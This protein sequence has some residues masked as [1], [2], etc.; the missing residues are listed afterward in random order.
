V[1]GE[2]EN[3]N[4]KRRRREGGGERSERTHAMTRD[5]ETH[6]TPRLRNET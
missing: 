1:G 5:S 2:S 3:E 6:W 4:E